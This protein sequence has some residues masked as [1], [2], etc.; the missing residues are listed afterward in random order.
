LLAGG[1]VAHV[2]AR[3]R[4]GARGPVHRLRKLFVPPC[5]LFVAPTIASQPFPVQLRMRLEMLGPTYIKLGQILSLRSDILPETVTNE[6]RNLLSDLPPAPFPE[7]RE[8]VE[9]DLGRPLGE[10]FKDVNE[11]PLGSASIAQTHRATT[12][13]GDLV[14]LKVVKP[15]IRTLLDRDATLLRFCARVL[16]M[17]LPQVQPMRI[18]D[19]FF[20]YTMREVDMN[21]EATN[22]ETFAANFRD[23]PDV[24]FPRMYR[25][26][27]GRSVLCMEYLKG[28]R[29]DDRAVLDLAQDERQ[30]LIDLGASAIIRMLY[31][32][33][34][35]HADLH[36]AN[37]LILP[38]PRIA[39]IDLGMVGRIDQS[40][41]RTLL[42]HFYS[43]VMGDFT[44]AARHLT[45][46]ADPGRGA[47]MAAF[48]R[49]VED[50]YRRWR[51]SA[52]FEDFSLA[53]LVLE[54]IRLGAKYRMY[55]PVEMVLM[56][57]ALVTYEGVG[58][59]LDQEFNVADVSVRHVNT[60]FRQTFNP[61]RL[62]REGLRSAPELMDA[63]VKTPLLMA[64][65]LHVLERQSRR[66][67]E[68]P[69]TGLRGT[70]FGGFCVLAASV[71]LAADGP[72]FVWS[73]L[74]GLG[75]L[76]SLR[77]GD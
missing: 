70:V 75:L 32:D 31:R 25:E 28:I 14:I 74:M 36:P 37:I 71:L 16:Q 22:A 17:V 43:L 34:F 8:T 40:L 19:E 27:S 66:Q 35:F 77:R 11:V 52:T 23:M 10:L 61:L 4:L 56:V 55:F 6:L 65:G 76:L 15:G 64:E 20:D 7:I 45:L 39:F 1:Y 51:R 30:H 41:C 47:D 68:N 29:P 49:A 67:P 2:E 33:G 69:T 54:A 42:Y 38:G 21:W 73:I 13:D 48:R 24:V 60:V 59:L 26:L 9:G 46:V 44:N 53:L 5:Q 58:Y 3:E 72:W 12:R 18:V 57:K 63:V 62:L 50:L